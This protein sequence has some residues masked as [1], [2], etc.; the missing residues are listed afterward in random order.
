MTIEELLELIKDVDKKSE[1]RFRPAHLN[2]TNE[3][4]SIRIVR[5]AVLLSDEKEY[6]T[7][8]EA[9]DYARFHKCGGCP[10]CYQCGYITFKKGETCS[11][12]FVEQN[13]DEVI[14]N[15]KPYYKLKRLEN[16]HY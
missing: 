8:E 9:L 14:K 6:F 12:V 7:R 1:I 13:F 5:G 10:N 15:N 3:I 4:R 16:N 11:D 2:N